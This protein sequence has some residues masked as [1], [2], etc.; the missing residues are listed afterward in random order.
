MNLIFLTSE[1]THHYYLI[2]KIHKHYP[3]KMVFFQAQQS[4]HRTWGERFRRWR[5]W[6]NIVKTI[7]GIL[8]RLLF[9][10]EGILEEQY[11]RDQFFNGRTPALNPSISSKKVSSF[12]DSKAVEEVKKESPDL[13][14][15]FGTEILKGDIL[16]IARKGILNIHRGIAPKYCGGSVATWALYHNDFENLGVTIHMCTNKLDAGDIV[17]QKYY[18]LQ[19]HDKIYTLRYK[20]TIIALEIL[21]KVLDQYND[22]TVE[23]QKQGPIQMW[24]S[25]DLTITKKIIA[26]KNFK[27]LIK[28]LSFLML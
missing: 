12:N 19:R 2:N 4:Q 11:E 17:G 8:D 28:K 7:K 3:V 27:K 23:Y 1:T 6:K 25:K 13:I 20:T 15:V 22:G 18:R 24:T 21:K 5:K 14:I 16:N 10:K 9:G 26:R